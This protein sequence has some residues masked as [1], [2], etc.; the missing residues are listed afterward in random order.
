ME[1]GGCLRRKE[2]LTPFEHRERRESH[3]NSFFNQRKNRLK[4]ITK[5]NKRI[6]ERINSQTSLYS[7]RRLESSR[8]LNN[9][10]NL[11]SSI[12]SQRSSQ[13]INSNSNNSRKQLSSHP[14]RG[15]SFSSLT[16]RST[17]S[18]SSSRNLGNKKRQLAN[19]KPIRIESKSIKNIQMTEINRYLNIFCHPSNQ[20]HQVQPKKASPLPQ[21]SIE[22]VEDK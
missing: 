2:A 10:R 19:S 11:D 16:R 22:I 15:Q 21:Q 9:S 3:L 4:D 12:Q 13:S 14:N 5:E 17:S 1:E 18:I 8:Q 6:Y 20:R 7:S